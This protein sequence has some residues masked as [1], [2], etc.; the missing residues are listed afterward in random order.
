MKGDIY[1][2][3][4]V[5][6]PKGVLPQP[7]L[8][9]NNNF[10]TIYDN[11]I[12]ISVDMLNID[13]ASYHQIK[14]ECNSDSSAMKKRIM[15]I[16][17]ERGKMQNPVT[18][19]GGML[20]GTVEK[21]GKDLKDKINLKEGDKIATLVSL[22]LTPLKIDSIDHLNP[23]KEQ[24]KITGKAVLFESGIY[25]K[26][27]SDIN[28]KL[29]LSVLDVAG[30]PLQ[31]ARLVSPNDTVLIMGANGKSGM[32]CSYV[33]KK[34]TGVGGKVFGLV[35]EDSN[36]D[37][38]QELG[39]EIIKGDAT[40]AVEV[41]KE[42]KR[43][44]DGNLCDIVINVVNVPNAEMACILSTKERGKVYFFSMA[45]SFT[46]AALGAEG[47]SKDVDMMIGNGYGQSHAD[48]ALE[49]MR[50]SKLLRERFEKLFG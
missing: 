28:E 24:V 27:P 7:A 32:L 48:Y 36:L 11:E 34:M 33:A 21:I 9:V 12:L 3:H 6:E 22:S 47:V 41:Y 29:A 13:S 49:I 43:R 35:Y 23:N 50:E 40:N 25:A 18:G 45:T 39:V 42:V 15:E 46:K 30:A 17:N 14:N 44:T 19:S 38:L 4:R 37:I 1:G 20:I 5:I 8:K 31:T 26:L 2:L 10:S 16:V